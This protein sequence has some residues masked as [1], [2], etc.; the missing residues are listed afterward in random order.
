M[1]VKPILLIILDGY[2]I[3]K[4]YPGNA[5]SLAKKPTIDFLTKHGAMTSLDASGTP[6]GLPKGQ[7]GNSEVGHMNIGSGRILLQA[8]DSINQAI[9]N[10]SFF[11]LAGLLA[12]AKRCKTNKSNLHLIGLVS[13]G[14]VHSHINHLYA[15]IEFACQQKIS[16]V[17][18]H[19]VLDGRDT[20]PTSALGFIKALLVKLQ[21][22]PNVKIAS[23]SGRYYTMDRDQRWNRLEKAYDVIVNAQGPNFEDPI[24]YLENQYQAKVNDEFVIPAFNSKIATPMHDQDEVI[25]FN[26][27]P[28]RAIQFCS[29]LSNPN[30]LWKPAH[31]PHVN[32]LTMTKYADSVISQVLF[33]PNVVHKTLG[34]IIAANNLAQLRIAETEK[35]AHVTYFFNGGKD[36]VFP[37]E[38]RILVPS[39]KVATYDLQPEMS[40][41]EIT[42]RLLVE[43]D[44]KQFALIVLN[45]ANCDMVGHSGNI[46]QTIKAVEVVDACLKRIVDKLKTTDG[47]LVLTADHGNADCMLDSYNQT[48]TSHSTNLVPLIIYSPTKQYVIKHTIGKLSDIAPTILTIMNLPIPRE[49]TG[50]ILISKT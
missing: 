12:L 15:L 38:E 41:V 16:N 6:V 3:N 10:H 13:D 46:A 4:S 35:Y 49:M 32:L 34:E 44:K 8:F 2:G 7:M 50:D 26:F 18:I 48:V 5:I 39:P 25:F 9:L 17:F 42:N 47:V 29:A 20:S 31:R 27:R 19:A 30:Y 11:K 45:F 23:L 28:D 40:A 14:G 24:V 37:K 33:P 36:E 22:Y 1:I 43:M 21:K